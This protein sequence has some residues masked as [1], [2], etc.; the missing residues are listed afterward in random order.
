MIAAS[1]IR[2]IF[3]IAGPKNGFFSYHFTKILVLGLKN[4]LLDI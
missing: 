2:T 1:F 3:K 4:M